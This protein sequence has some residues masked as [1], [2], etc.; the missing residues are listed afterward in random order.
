[1]AMPT[2]SDA[3]K[4]SMSNSR[5]ISASFENYT[6]NSAHILAAALELE[7]NAVS[8]NILSSAPNKDSFLQAIH[9]SANINGKNPDE[10]KHPV[11][12]PAGSIA[13]TNEAEKII[14]YA[15]SLGKKSPDGKVE[16]RHLISAMLND[17]KCVA[18]SLLTDNLNVEKINSEL[19]SWADS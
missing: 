14:E 13:L 1:M 11:G 3:F 7:G 19:S 2:F 15:M 8:Q 9:E 4:A 10:R 17:K 12:I 6:I 5:K 16:V 18:N